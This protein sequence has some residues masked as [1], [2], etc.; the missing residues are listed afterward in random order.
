MFTDMKG[1]TEKTSVHSRSQLH[2][3]LDLQDEL[4]KPAIHQFSGRI[5]KTIGD[6]FLV[7]FESPTDAVL[8]GM[9]IQE[10]VINHNVKASSSDQFD[11]RIAVNSGEVNVR[12]NDVFGEAVNIASRIESIAEPN[13]VY[14]TEAVYLSMNRNEIPTAEVGYR[15]LKGIPEE[16]K[17]YKVLL[18]RTNLIRMRLQRQTLAKNNSNLAKDKVN[19]SPTDYASL[20]NTSDHDAKNKFWD[21]YK[22]HIIIAVIICLLLFFF[23]KLFN[24]E[25]K[26]NSINQETSS[27]ESIQLEENKVEEIL[28]KIDESSVKKLSPKEKEALISRLMEIKNSTDLNLFQRRRIDRILNNLR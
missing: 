9:K 25:E 5:V 8:C 15:R 1:F 12:E 19:N 17:V 4:V 24:K 23:L 14:F 22:K 3:L 11:I 28:K 6:A 7:A 18:E 10:N 27:P 26:N 2:H 16:I 20:K 13:E 21:K